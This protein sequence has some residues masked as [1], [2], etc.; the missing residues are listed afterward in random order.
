[1]P[2]KAF[3]KKYIIRQTKYKCYCAEPSSS[4]VTAGQWKD[5]DR[6]GQ[7]HLSVIITCCKI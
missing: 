4:A 7:H 2:Y 3:L 1:M 5:R 6:L